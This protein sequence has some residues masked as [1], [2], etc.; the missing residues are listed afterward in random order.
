MSSDHLSPTRSS[1]LAIS[2]SWASGQLAWGLALKR[3]GL[4]MTPEEREPPGIATRAGALAARNAEEGLDDADALQAL[5]AD[6]ELTRAHAL[7]LP[8]APPRP[9][10]T[11]DTD[12]TLAQAK[13]VEAETIADAR[14]WLTPKERV[15][16]LDDRALLDRLSRLKPAG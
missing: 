6:P 4:L 12:R 3:L 7:M 1:V 11:I 13:V 15:A 8:E 16:L 9:R 10:G 2:I 14:A 5:H